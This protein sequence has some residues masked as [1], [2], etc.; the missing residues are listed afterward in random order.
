MTNPAQ[1]EPPV[2]GDESI[3][4]ALAALQLGEDVGAHHEQLA[5]ALEAL[6]RALNRSN[7]QR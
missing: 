4:R 1:T 3:D 5:A 6:Q 7:E 2:T